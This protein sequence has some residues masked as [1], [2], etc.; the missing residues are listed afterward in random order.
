MSVPYYSQFETPALIPALLADGFETGLPGDPLW[1]LSGAADQ[2][3]YVTWA[4]N[5]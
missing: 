3:E 2:A 4:A 1:H 5:V